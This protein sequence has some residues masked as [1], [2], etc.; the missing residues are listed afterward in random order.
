MKDHHIDRK[1][2]N[3]TNRGILNEFG[4]LYARMRTRPDGNAK[5]MDER[6]AKEQ[7]SGPRAPQRAYEE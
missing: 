3:P 2:I 4:V 5:V 1:H 7:A 6:E